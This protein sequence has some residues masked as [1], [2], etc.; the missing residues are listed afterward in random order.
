MQSFVNELWDVMA[1][2]SN[3]TI[4]IYSFAFVGIIIVITL[5]SVYLDKDMSPTSFYRMMSKSITLVVGFVM[6]ISITLF[7]INVATNSHLVKGTIKDYHY[8]NEESRMTL[9]VNDTDKDYEVIGIANRYHYHEG[10]TLYVNAGGNVIYNTLKINDQMIKLPLSKHHVVFLLLFVTTLGVI[11]NAI[12]DIIIHYLKES[13]GKETFKEL[14]DVILLIVSIFVGVALFIILISSS[15]DSR[16]T[17]VKGDVVK[18][19]DSNHYVVKDDKTKVN[20]IIPGE[21]PHDKQVDY[22]VN[23][24]SHKIEKDN[25]N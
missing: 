7:I 16:V 10:D 15:I 13:Q 14:Y 4:L 8:N 25:D 22:Q 17:H 19:I 12:V 11:F 20:Y 18:E 9:N 3:Q 5:L 2:A 23:K 24:V 6:L 21:I 1:S